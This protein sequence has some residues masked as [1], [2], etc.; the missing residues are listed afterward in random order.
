VAR[1]PEKPQLLNWLLRQ[2]LSGVHSCTSLLERAAKA[3]LSKDAIAAAAYTEATLGPFWNYVLT[4]SSEHSLRGLSPSFSVQDKETKTWRCYPLPQ[5]IVGAARRR[6]VRSRSRPAVLQMIHSL[7]DRQYEALSCVLLEALG[8]TKVELTRAGNEGGV[9]AFGLIV[10]PNS[11][12]ILG[13]VHQPIRVVLQAKKHRRPMSAD[14]MKEFLQTLNE[15]KHGGQSKTEAIVPSWF[16]ASRGAIVGLAM[17]HSGFQSGAESRARSHGVLIV[18][19]IDV[20]EV[21]AGRRSLYGKANLAKITAC[22]QRIA[23]LLRDDH[24]QSSGTGND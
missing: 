12:H 5:E 15:V 14:K 13:S 4:V 24:Q 3:C 7:D 21:I 1:E 16:R 10:S 18:E 20:A 9:D 2:D 6:A 19:S 22:L 17:S 8:A 11:S 23:E